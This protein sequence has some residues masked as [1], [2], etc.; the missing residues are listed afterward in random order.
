VLAAAPHIDNGIGDVK[1]M[2]IER[3]RR[4][5]SAAAASSAVAPSR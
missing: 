4:R 3:S 2:A 1:Q 5:G